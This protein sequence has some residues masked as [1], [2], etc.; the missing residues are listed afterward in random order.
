[1]PLVIP[2]HRMVGADGGLHGYG[3]LGGLRTKAWLQKLEKAG[4]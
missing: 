4:K 3:G 1:M 2:C